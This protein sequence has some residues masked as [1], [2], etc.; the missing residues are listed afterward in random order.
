VLTVRSC[1]EAVFRYSSTSLRNSCLVAVRTSGA[2]RRYDCVRNASSG[3]NFRRLVELYRKTASLQDRTVS[4]GVL[5]PALARQYGTGGYVGR[6][7]GRQTD[8]RRWPGYAPYPDLAFDIPTL[9]EGD[10]D[11]RF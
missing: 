10:V 4:T 7:S 8:A 9:Q 3:G 11:A 1:R 6:A 5:Q 2:R